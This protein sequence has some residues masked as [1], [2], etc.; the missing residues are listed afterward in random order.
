[1]DFIREI[2]ENIWVQR[3]FWSIIVILV[4]VLIYVIIARFLT[5]KE[6]K[7]SKILSS[8]KNKTFIRMLKS[9]VAYTLGIFTLL[10]ILQIFGINVTSML[11][12]VGIAG[13]IIGFALQDA[14]KDIFRG[15]EIISDNYYSIGD[16]IK[17][18]NNTGRVQSVTLRTTKI[19]DINTMNI[20]SIAN[21]NIDQVEVLSGNIYIPI[22]LPY[23]LKVKDAEA[24]MEE[25]IK[26]LGKKDSVTSAKY[27]GI[28]AFSDSSLNY[29]IVVTCDPA[30][31]LQVRRDALRVIVLTLEDHKLSVPYP[32]LDIHT[33]K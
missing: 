3:C 32:Q 33:K 31:Q 28:N 6:K 7:G 22:P 23:E 9:L 12:G 15:F 30:D 16:V 24:I 25:I 18:G 13:I 8:K 10:V 11:A 27:Q 4:S 26:T 29:Q 14:L 21:R 1:M 17:F 20:V 2:T 19:Q 5:N